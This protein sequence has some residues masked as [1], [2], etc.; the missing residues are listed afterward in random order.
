MEDGFVSVLPW[1][2]ADRVG[3]LWKSG[4]SRAAID[5]EIESGFSPRGVG[6][7]RALNCE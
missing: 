2:R 7:C 4:P 1:K 3:L 5:A 6:R